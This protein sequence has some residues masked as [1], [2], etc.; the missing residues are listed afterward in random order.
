MDFIEKRKRK[1]GDRKDGHW[2]KDAP[3]M[4]VIMSGLYPKR[5]NCELSHT[6]KIDITDLMNYIEK[7]NSEN[8]DKKIKFFHCFIAALSRV[9]NERRYLNRFVSRCRIYERDEIL[10]SFVAKRQFKD[11]A[12]EAIVTYK[13]KATDN[14]DNVSSFI[15]GEVKSVRTEEDMSKSKRK[16]TKDITKSLDSIAKLPRFLIMLITGFARLVDYYGITP[17][18]LKRGDPAY[19]TILVANLGSINCEPCYHH[20]NNYGTC[21]IVMTIGKFYKQNVTLEDNTVEVRTF[22]DVTSTLDE[23]IADGF[24]FSKSVSL[25]ANYLQHPYSLE[26]QFNEEVNFEE[27][28]NG[29]N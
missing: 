3:G 6:T 5:C 1:F 14:I 8:P 17:K 4:N 22:V 18:F 19:S 25:L 12:K 23:R 7:R 10:F 9:V 21:S 15:L 26:K 16:E 29:N 11:T 13:P 20:L 27:L 2:V 28:E 24:Y